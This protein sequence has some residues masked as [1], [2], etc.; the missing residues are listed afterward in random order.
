MELIRRASD[1]SVDASQA[2]DMLRKAFGKHEAVAS[3]ADRIM[4]RR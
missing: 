2:R 4:L 1:R 3:L